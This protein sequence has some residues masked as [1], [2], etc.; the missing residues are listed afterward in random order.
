MIHV[1]VTVDVENPQ[2]PLFEKRFS[3]NRIWSNGWGI[4]KIIDVLNRYNIKGA[5]FT[6]VYEY[7]IW[8]K[9]EM[10]RIVKYI[11]NQGHDVELH[12]HPIWIDKKRREHMFQ[13]SYEEQTSVLQ[14]GID[15]IEKWCGRRPYCH[16]AGAYGFNKDTLGACINAGI[17]V[18]SS[19]FYGH[20]NCRYILAENDPV[21]Y[22][23]I[24]EMPVTFFNR[25]DS[26][27]K[28]DINWMSKNEFTC[29][30]NR[31][32]VESHSFINLFLHSYSLT[33]T[34]DSFKTFGEDRNSLKK[35]EHIVEFVSDRNEFIVESL[36]DS[37]NAYFPGVIHS[38]ISCEMIG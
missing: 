34:N 16:R 30:V 6:N 4:E 26:Y 21:V 17:A 35:F 7:P 9:K 2:T 10:E 3:D 38:G 13:F 32:K 1:A 11:H 19:S 29:L 5:F 8:G 15:L 28:T 14:H 36:Y 12:T 23:N 31:M 20:A 24:I 22:K 25:N 18:D 37:A 33:K 27:V